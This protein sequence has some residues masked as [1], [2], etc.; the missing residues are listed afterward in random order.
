MEK[1][2]DFDAIERFLS[3][4]MSG[5]ELKN[6]QQRLTT[7]K[8]FSD[9]VNLHQ[10]VISGIKRK[11]ND[12]EFKD[13]IYGIESDLGQ[14]GFYLSEDDFDT[15]IMG[16]VTDDFQ[17]KFNRRLASDEQFKK[18]FQLHQEIT[19]G[20]ERKGSEDEFANIIA[21]L[22][23]ENTETEAPKEQKETAKVFSLRRVM[24]IAASVLLIAL[25]GW[26]F[27][28]GSSISNE[29]LFANFYQPH[30]SEQLTQQ[31]NKEIGELGFAGGNL[32]KDLISLK[33]SLV[34][35]EK[36]DFKNALTEIE[37]FSQKYPNRQDA[38]LLYGI[39]LLENNQ[40]N[41]AVQV[42][43][44]IVQTENPQQDAAKWY[45]A[46]T[47]IKQGNKDVAIPI[48]QQLTQ[49]TTDFKDQSQ[50]LLKELTN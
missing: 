37:M 12:D 14:E 15:M 43:Q 16:E 26:W 33:E 32:K 8:D 5:E 2:F 48:L 47:Y 24:A 3:N 42:F 31:T 17:Q 38:K 29:Q 44:Q 18:D 23:E 22:G 27:V 9:A 7:D 34:Q 39:S 1:D 25:A 21:G 40:N 36:G 46:L 11:G 20:I 41:K 13:I 35:Y 10:E 28:S 49:T 50:R 30:S 19:K 4:E 45:L 6:F